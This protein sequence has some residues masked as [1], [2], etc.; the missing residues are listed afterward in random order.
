MSEK[1]IKLFENCF[2][3]KGAK[4]G[5]IADMQ[6]RNYY[7]VPN[8]L[9][10]LFDENHVFKTD[11]VEKTQESE[12][13]IKEYVDFLIENELCF[14]CNE[15]L[16]SNFPVLDIDAWDYPAY[17]TN[18][19]IEL[20]FRRPEEGI[21]FL[22]ELAGTCLTRHFEVHTVGIVD[23]DMADRV[24]TLID[25]LDLYSYNLVIGFN[26]KEQ[27]QGIAM[28]Q[29]HY[30][31]FRTIVHSADRDDIIL[32]DKAGWGNIFLQKLPFSHNQ[33]GVVDVNYFANNLEHISESHQHNTCL[34]RKIAIDKDGNIKNCL[35]MC[36]NHG[37]IKTVNVK[38]VIRDPMFT[39][40][41][42]IK[43]DDIAICKDCEFRHICTD[44]RAFTEDPEDIYSK[45]LKCG[46]DP[47][48]NEWQEWST[49]PFKQK[50][51]EFYGMNA[52]LTPLKS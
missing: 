19:V 21:R 28:L 9:L 23:V 46:Y 45:P 18:A 2:I 24:L 31:I 48:T 49:L 51:M 11:V 5:M 7:L 12:R 41:W 15:S 8:S 50:A 39:Q 17:V 22:K 52:H 43:K 32:S 13:I 35:S 6:R 27:Y 20:D 1:V 14:Y 4:R 34:N 10:L 25:D 16:V 44:C 30:K 40:Y 3:S 42:H 38:D 29:E 36:R 37:H 26:A 33:C 47:Y